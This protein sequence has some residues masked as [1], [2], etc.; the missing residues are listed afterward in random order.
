MVG[1]RIKMRVMVSIEHPAWAHQFKSIIHMLKARGDEV[2]VVAIQKDGD[3]TLLDSFGI[4]YVKLGDSTGRNTFEKA[5][6]FLRTCYTYSRE[7]LRFKPDVLIGRASPMMAFAAFVVH[8]PHILFEETEISRF[9][10]GMCRLLS[11]EILTPDN[12][13]GDLGKKQTRLPLVKE[14]FFL[15]P[16]R[17]TPDRNKLEAY[18]FDTNEP[19]CIV[20]FISWSASHDV[21]MRGLSAQQMIDCVSTLERYCKHVYITSEAPLPNELKGHAIPLPYDMIHHALYYA[22]LV[23]SEGKSVAMEAALLG[24]HAVY[25]NPVQSGATNEIEQRF[26][27]I[28]Q[29]GDANVDLRLE[30]GLQKAVELLQDADLVELGKRK[31]A[32]LLDSLLDAS[33]VFIERMD[34]LLPD[35]E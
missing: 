24:T 22:R 17:F 21:N 30:A 5:L 33:A 26:E 1:G 29:F 7:A 2:L 13:L 31:R 9:S 25:I 32:A 3:L 34:A 12:F 20:R 8:K 23:F 19:Y 15:H 6:I 28:Y 14:A 27:L 11:T 35:Q 10:L 16:N 18:G 4:P